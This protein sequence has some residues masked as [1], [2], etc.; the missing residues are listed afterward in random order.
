MKWGLVIVGVLLWSAPARAQVTTPS[1]QTPQ[2]VYL[3]SSDGTVLGSIL[4][5]GA[6]LVSFRNSPLVSVAPFSSVIPFPV[7]NPPGALLS[8]QSSYLYSN[9]ATTTTFTLKV[10]TGVLHTLNINTAGSGS[11][12][13]L[14]D[15]TV[16]NG[17]LIAVVNTGVFGGV[18][19]YDAVFTTG[20]VAVTT[21]TTAANL[22]VTWR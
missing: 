12:I 13:S 18:L 21:G 20:L 5:D 17:P 16:G 6:L 19:I 4:A 7:I 22:T 8:V 15:N 11:S 14:F 3:V 9:L 1:G 2:A 10:G